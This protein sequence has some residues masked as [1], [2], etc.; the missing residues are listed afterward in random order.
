M[1]TTS[2]LILAVLG[3]YTIIAIAIAIW[4]DWVERK[5]DEVIKQK[6][7]EILEARVEYAR[8]S[9]VFCASDFYKIGMTD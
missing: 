6:A 9:G 2:I 4:L 1:S 5:A 8:S 7:L 3:V